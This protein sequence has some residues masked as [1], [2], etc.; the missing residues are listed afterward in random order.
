MV[1]L[2][3]ID[4][5]TSSVV[6]DKF[7]DLKDKC[8]FERPEILKNLCSGLYA[9]QWIVTTPAGERGIYKSVPFLAMPGTKLP[10][11]D[12]FDMVPNFWILCISDTS[13][14]VN[15]PLSTI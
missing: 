2:T 14:T 7:S 6:L 8:R 15:L 1:S 5:L 4:P 12:G 3:V 13:K 10:A 11:P 9:Y